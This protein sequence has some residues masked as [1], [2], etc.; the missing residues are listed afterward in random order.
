ME[1]QQFQVRQVDHIELYVPDQ[2]QAARW[3]EQVL[4]LKIIPEYTFWADEGGPLM[5]SSDGGST[6]LA[7]FKG[8]P[9]GF[10]SPLIGFRRVAFRV[11][12]PGFLEFLERL[13]DHPVF[14]HEGR[15]ATTLSVVD[16][17]LAYSVYFCDPYGN[18]YEVTTYDYEHVRSSNCPKEQAHI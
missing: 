10:S 3:Y 6:K 14:D 13:G 7:L 18:R 9:P 1:T 17:D 4:G 5:I 2:Y 8:E 12:G 16:H 15:P 11:D